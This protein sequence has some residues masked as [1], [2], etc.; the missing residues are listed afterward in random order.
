MKEI[1]HS[2]DYWS[3]NGYKII[4]GSK[5]SCRNKDGRPLFSNKQ[6]TKIKTKIYDI[7]SDLDKDDY[8]PYNPDYR[9]D[10]DLWISPL[11]FGDN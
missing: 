10:D 11:D 9:E 3:K 6:I 4:K 8:E 7:Y 1:F 5:S 2:F